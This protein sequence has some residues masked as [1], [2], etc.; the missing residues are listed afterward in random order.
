MF[1][2][3][4]QR[5]STDAD[6]LGSVRAVQLDVTSDDCVEACA[7]LV[8]ERF[9]RLDALINNA[10]F[11]D[12][13]VPGEPM[14]RKKFRN[15]R[16][17]CSMPNRSIYARTVFITSELGSNGNTLG[18]TFPCHGLDNIPY[19]ASQA[20]LSMVGTS[21][22]VE[23][24]LK[25]SKSTC[26]APVSERISLGTWRVPAIQA[27]VASI[28]TDSQRCGMKKKARASAIRMAYSHGGDRQYQFL[29]LAGHALIRR[30]P[31]GGLLIPGVWKRM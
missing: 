12:D 10:V 22:N 18:P 7:T 15:Q 26:A 29:M 14:L 24:A 31:S 28:L 3:A 11:F 20:A 13:N 5:Y 17:R 25:G 23:H 1:Q 30:Y 27:K 8:E 2:N 16:L 21:Y 19:N 4:N 9:G 6:L